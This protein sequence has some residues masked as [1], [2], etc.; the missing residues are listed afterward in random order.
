M[1]KKKKTLIKAINMS[2]DIILAGPFMND[3]T[4]A[5]LPDEFITIELTQTNSAT[6]KSIKNLNFIVARSAEK[7]QT[8]AERTEDSETS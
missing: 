8:D 5:I 1:T 3:E 4:V 7:E 2:D 6:P